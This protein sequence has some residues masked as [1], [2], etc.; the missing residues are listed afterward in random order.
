MPNLKSYNKENAI[1]AYLNEVKTVSTGKLASVIKADQ[2]LTER[3]L[4]KLLAEKKVRQIVM[5][6]ATYWEL[7]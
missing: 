3:I 5:P 1:L 2:Y 7:K 4:N 6:H